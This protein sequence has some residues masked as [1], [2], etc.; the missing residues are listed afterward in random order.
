MSLYVCSY[1]CEIW[2][3]AAQWTQLCSISWQLSI[4]E[5]VTFWFK[6]WEGGTLFSCGIPVFNFPTLNLWVFPVPQGW[7][8]PTVDI[9][10]TQSCFVPAEKR[11][12]ADFGSVYSIFKIEQATACVSFSYEYVYIHIHTISVLYVYFNF[13]CDVRGCFGWPCGTQAF[14]LLVPFLTVRNKERLR[15]R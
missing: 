6:W 3:L 4:F 1:Q 12:A 2:M 5:R 7:P 15:P 9:D 10:G 8:N 13:R 14:P 11:K